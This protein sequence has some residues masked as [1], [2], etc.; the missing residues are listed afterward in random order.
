MAI[1]P[2]TSE[3]QDNLNERLRSLKIDRNPPPA[4]STQNRLPKMLLLGLAVL[5]A[6]VAM[7]YFYFFSAPKAIS[8]A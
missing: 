1:N 6:L 4:P 5:V 3:E 8:V 7:G 2:K